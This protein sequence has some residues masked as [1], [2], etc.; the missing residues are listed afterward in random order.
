MGPLLFIIKCQLKNII[1]GIKKKP[2]V[3]IGYIFLLIMLIAFLVFVIFSPSGILRSGSNNLFRAI[4]TGLLCIA[5]YL[6][7]LQGIEKGSSLFR[8][9]DVNIVFTA[10]FKSYHVLFYGFLKQAGTSLLIV[11]I[12]IAQIPNLKNNFHL[13]KYGT[14]VILLTVLLYTLL[15]P[16]IGMVI[17]TFT[18]RS[19]AIR[20]NAKQ[21]INI[22]MILFLS[23]FAYKIILLKS[24]S[25]ALTAFFSSDLFYYI[26][27]IG[28]MSIIAGSAVGGI[29]LSFY[30]SIAI[31][32]VFI[33]LLVLILVRTNPDYYEDV[34]VA[35]EIK[36]KKI[37]EKKEGKAMA[38]VNTLKMKFTLNGAGA[39][40]Q[41]HL[42][43]Y[44][45]TSFFLFFDKGTLLIIFIAIVFRYT[46]HWNQASI[47]VVLFFSVYLLFF[48][49]MQGKWSRE[50]ERPYIFLIPARP[51][52]KL[53]YA[54]L[55]EN[56]KNMLD[57]ILLFAITGYLFKV[58]PV[59][60]GLCAI[61][62]FLYG[63]V[64]IYFNVISQRLFGKVHTR[65]MK[66]FFKLF[67]V[68]LVIIPG[69][70]LMIIVAVLTKNQIYMAGT[71]VVWNFIAANIMLLLAKGIFANMDV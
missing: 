54:T 40:F 3:L 42:L 10:P 2:I 45:K 1:R 12:T 47:F 27:V 60:A 66:F 38:S 58:D 20:K 21:L 56:I 64:Y 16:I 68:G 17:Y 4:M 28:Q 46:L 36:E 63:A 15:T 53:L 8:F 48:T 14:P 11:L 5:F 49:V 7:L 43:E 51:V 31:L 32:L 37:K 18:S 70:V 41:K 33:L 24:F 34:L 52:Q 55:T 6:S 39:I 50:L 59:V 9:S 23:G 26:P 13:Q 35:T 61:N 30:I 29:S 44:R 57:G 65:S 69:I 25:K 71:I 22:I 19:K 67:M 62:F